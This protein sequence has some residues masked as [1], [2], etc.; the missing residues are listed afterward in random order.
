MK[1]KTSVSRSAIST[2]ASIGI[3]VILVIAAAIGVFYYSTLGTSSSTTTTSTSQSMTHTTTT[4]TTGGANEPTFVSDNSLIYETAGNFQWLDPSVSYYQADYGIFQNVFEKLLWFN[5]DNSSQLIPWLATDMPTTNDGGHT[6]TLHL[7]QGITFADGTPFNATAVW[8]SFTRL[9]IL[10]G[11]AGDQSVHGSQAAWIIQ[12]LLNTSLSSYFQGSGSQSYDAAWV[13]AVLAE[14]FVQIIDPYTVQF[15]V[16]NPSASFPYLISNEWADIMSPSWVVG[17]DDAS[18][19]KSHMTTAD[20]LPYWQEFA[21]LNKLTSMILPTTAVMAGTGPYYLASADGTT[22]DVVLKANTHYWG[23]P[24]GFT[25]AGNTMSSLQPHIATIYINYVADPNT[26]LLDMKAAK[27]TIVDGSASLLYSYINQNTWLTQQKMVSINPGITQYGTYPTLITEWFEFGSNITTASGSFRTFQPFADWRLREAVS[28]AV[29]MTDAG[30]NI[31]NGLVQTANTLAPPGTNPGGSYSTSIP[32]NQEYNLTYAAQLLADAA[33]HPL[34]SAS[35]TMHYYNGTVIPAG[36]VDNTFSPTN[37]QVITL[38]YVA[39]GTVGQNII[40]EIAT[41]LNAITSPPHK[42][43]MGLTFVT[44]P[45]PS[46]T[47]YTQMADHHLDFAPAGW[48][49]D[50]NWVTDWTGPM[51]LSSGTYF[52]WSLWNNTALDS[53]VSQGLAADAAGNVGQLTTLS[54]QAQNYENNL[55]YYMWEFY[56]TAYYSAST[57]LHGFYY[58]IAIGDSGYYFPTYS[59]SAPS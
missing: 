17:H 5:G 45:L 11:T 32:S 40:N 20:Y 38:T 47:R 46:S 43:G 23:G 55:H 7:R 19:L 52:S 56:P 30:I 49:A 13:N 24:S 26:Q 34:T 15:N 42:T 9:L 27:A 2:S 1:I 14:N 39:G 22:Y 53:L 37:P 57:W 8:F 58:N 48:V 29:N 33:A 16:Q 35:S 12:Q 3:V 21:G 59:Y 4:T 6:Y 51:F 28:I 54:V 18:L 50:Y 31:A 41:N 44:Q 25:V 10:D 36:V